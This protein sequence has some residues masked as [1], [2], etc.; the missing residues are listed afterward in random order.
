[1]N[2]LY[3]IRLPFD[4]SDEDFFEELKKIG[5]DKSNYFLTKKSLD[6]RNKNSIF[7]IY[8]I[9]KEKPGMQ[10]D[11]KEVTKSSKYSPLIVGCGPAGIF[12]AYWLS[13][14]GIASTIIEQGDCINDR[15]KKIARFIKTGELDERSNVCFGAG[16]A[17]TF[18]DGKLFT[19]IK[20]DKIHFVLET[21]VKFGAPKEILYDSHPHIGSN[22]LREVIN[23]ILSYLENSG[24]KIV[25]QTKLTDFEFLNEK[26]N[27]KIIKVISDKGEFVTDTVFLATGHSAHDIFHKL[28]DLKVSMEFKPFAVGLRIEHKSELIDRIQY[29]KF[30]GHKKL[31]HATYKLAHTWKDQNR[32]VYSFCMC[33]G[34]YIVN[35]STENGKMVCNG[36]S[37]SRR[38]GK[39]SNSAIV[40][41]ILEEDIAGDD[42][43][44]GLK[45]QNTLEKKFAGSVNKDGSSHVLP[46]MKVVD[47]IDRK[48]T[49]SVLETGIIGK[50]STYPLHE[51]LPDFI[52]KSIVD[53]LEIFNR[54]M[55]GFISPEAIFAGIETR[56]SSPVRIVRDRETYQSINTQGL[57]P[58]GEGAGYAGGITSSSIDGINAACAY[59]H[60]R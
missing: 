22:K 21:F 25:F 41:N 9:S 26:A 37:N 30:A 18:S 60:A 20:S 6:A 56:T 54:Q 57:Y 33:P 4:H 35:S 34:G 44:K 59:I 40:V 28:K 14:H 31:P 36:M 13:L 23:N 15:I 48:K 10:Y 27:K 51:L 12:T 5:L 2:Q 49:A 39:F 46:V 53:G 3:S 55:R 11:F 47:F 42:V 52:Y 8:T 58:I 32:G 16:G 38:E 19:G 17:G 29:G 45:F 7:S 43:F 24:T 1:M 50:Y